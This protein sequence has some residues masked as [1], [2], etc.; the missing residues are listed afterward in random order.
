M[1]RIDDIIKEKLSRLESIPDRFVN[2]IG[3]TQKGVMA[4]IESIIFSLDRDGETFLLNEKNLSLINSIEKK[5]KE[6]IFNDEYTSELTKYISQFKQQANLNNAYFTELSDKFDNKDVYKLS[7]E[8]SQKNAIAL[9]GEDSFSQQ[10]IIPITQS[11]QSSV[12]SSISFTETLS[13]L[14]S[15]IE[16]SDQVDGRLQGYVKRIAYDAFSASDRSY[17]NVVANDLGLQF[18]KY[19]G[20]EVEDT[21]PFCNER[22]GKY[23]H[24]KEI[25]LWGENE[26]CCG[27]EWPNSKG[28]QGRN[29]ATNKATIFIF[30]G[31]YNCKDSIL[32][33][34]VKSVPGSVIQRA[35]DAGYYKPT[36]A[37]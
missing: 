31:G 22:R 16:G 10:L 24:K 21:R 30:A 25:E 11:L 2:A 1:A 17:T 13:S 36:K 34:S 33:V 14:R 15:F 19:Q 7:L 12:N 29:S 18:Y 3:K 35:I 37:A 8:A 26:T 5:L 9:L 27:L 32:P 4:D 20:V 28:W 6:T 23:F